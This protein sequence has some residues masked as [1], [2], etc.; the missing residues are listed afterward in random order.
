MFGLLNLNKPAGLTS[1]DVVN[2][3]Q[4]LLP[5]G[6]K[7][8]HAGTLDPLATGVLLVCI[9]PAT[10]LVP[11]IHE[12]SKSYE[13]SFILGRE[14]D[15]DDIQG[16]LREIPVSDIIT[17]DDIRRLLPEF[18]G[19]IS[20]VPPAYSAI[21]ING[22]R[23]HRIARRGGEVELAPRSVT[24]TRLELIRFEFPEF[25]LRID[26]GTGTYIRSLG[27]DLARR[28]GTSAV[29]TRL[30]RTRVGPC[31][32][33]DAC[34]VETLDPQSLARSLLSPLVVLGHLPRICLPPE[35]AGR[36]CYGQALDWPEEIDRHARVA[37]VNE[38]GTL[39]AIAGEKQGRLAPQMVFPMK[40]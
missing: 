21:K 6:V 20:Q 15:T 34:D 12:H 28:L 31:R 23:A 37:V 35:P 27:R 24:V 13:G 1:R 38:A 25:S 4:R 11:L 36:L 7:S 30:V 26:C 3:V 32:L 39:L 40:E 19:V 10:R 5:K 16:Q 22:Q 14:S 17:A 8:G 33:P 9:G 29:M 2:R 18:T